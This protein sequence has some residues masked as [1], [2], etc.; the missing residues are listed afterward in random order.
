MW[1]PNE[2]RSISVILPEGSDIKAYYK[3]KN[4]TVDSFTETSGEFIYKGDLLH[5]LET[6]FPAGDYLIRINDLT[7]GQVQYLDLEVGVDAWIRDT[8]AKVNRLVKKVD[9]ESPSWSVR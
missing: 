9:L 5:E 3:S 6:S 1:K 4:S 2:L 7:N 8:N